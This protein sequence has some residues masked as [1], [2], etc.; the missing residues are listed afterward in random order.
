MAE[1]PVSLVRED[2]PPVKK[3]N[4]SLLPP[5]VEIGERLAIARGKRHSTVIEKL[6]GVSDT[7]IGKCE[8]G[9]QAPNLEL[10]AYYETRESIPIGLILFGATTSEEGFSAL[11]IRCLSLSDEQ[12]HSLA[13]ELLA[14]LKPPGDL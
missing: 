4:K 5:N 8:K 12:R 10:L 6:S 14:S 2:L 13:T 3:V 9:Q 7:I 1:S 11:R